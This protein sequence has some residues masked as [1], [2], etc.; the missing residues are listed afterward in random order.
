VTRIPFTARR[1]TAAAALAYVIAAGVENMELLGAPGFGASAE[2]IRAA[3]AGGALATTT[4]LA[5]ALS[6]LAYAGF[7]AGLH[8]LTGGSRGTAAC[9]V[10]SAP[11]ARRGG[12]RAR[13]ALALAPTPADRCGGFPPRVA[14][15]AG[16]N[17]VLLGAAGLVASGLL[18]VADRSDEAVRVLA[19]LQLTLRLLA[20]PA[21]ALFLVAGG[22]AAVRA[23]VLRPWQGR[24]GGAV[25][26]LLALTPLAAVLE[27]TP[28]VAAAF[29]AF[30]LH[31]LWIWLAGLQLA[32]GL[33]ARRS[34]FL[35][36]VLAAGLVGVALLLVP[37]ATGAY[38]AWELKPAG[39]AAFAGGVYAGSAV[40]YGAALAAGDRAVRGL[41]AGAV[42]LCTSVLAITVAHRAA[43]DFG[44]LQAWAW[45][46]LFA[47]FGLATT[48][49]L[50]RAVRSR[51]AALAAPSAR[52]GAPSRAT[53]A[54]SARGLLAL[55]GVALAAVGLGLWADPA[56]AGLPPL[57]GR[58]AGSWSVMLAVAAL[59]GAVR[60]DAAEARL[61][62]LALVALPAGALLGAARTGTGGAGYVA[63]LLLLMAAGAVVTRSTGPARRRDRVP[64]VAWRDLP[65]TRAQE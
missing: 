59:W 11:A 26:C 45:V 28:A 29:V 25:A 42:A 37:G 55:A 27:S 4:W 39:L 7:V 34:A 22:G 53:L 15:A 36:L 21:M 30:G 47:G 61:P 44:R 41:L 56:A 12:L 2:A 32:V 50:A 16:A 31:A 62:A 19:E 60:D 58:F 24:L 35:M 40:V 10:P 9:A 5:G 54:P 6:L 8:R 33:D 38:F 65:A 46:V 63:A 18:V 64:A 3:Y 57:G 43:F 14:L 1:V 17:A 52:A 49:L 13:I 23:G 20:G 51:P 48:A